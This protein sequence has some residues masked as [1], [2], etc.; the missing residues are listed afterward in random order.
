MFLIS[1]ISRFSAVRMG[2]YVGFFVTVS[3]SYD[4]EELKELETTVNCYK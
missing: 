2:D 1:W 4:S 3:A